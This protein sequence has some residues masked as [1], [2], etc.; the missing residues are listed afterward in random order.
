M[1]NLWGF[2]LISSMALLL[3]VTAIAQDEE[4]Y[5]EFSYGTVTA[6]DETRNEITVSEYDWDSDSEISVTYLLDPEATMNTIASIKEI[7][8]GSY[9]DIEY[10]IDEKGKRI[11]KSVSIYESEPEMGE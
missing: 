4:I 7:M 6:V 3:T 11:A 5:T 10:I 8:P 1:K 9:I 2:F